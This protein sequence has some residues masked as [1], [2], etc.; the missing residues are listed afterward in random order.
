VQSLTAPRLV[1]IMIPQQAVDAVLLDLSPLLVKGDAV[2]DGGNPP[3][4]ESKRRAS[5]LKKR[6]SILSMPE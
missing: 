3:Y 4:K 6:A 5:E 1:R 2:I